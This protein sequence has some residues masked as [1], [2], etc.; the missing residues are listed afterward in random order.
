MKRFWIFI[1]LAILTATQCSHPYEEGMLGSFPYIEMTSPSSASFKANA[2]NSESMK[3]TILLNT[4]M[5]VTAKVEYNGN[6]TGWIS[7]VTSSDEGAAVKLTYTVSANTKRSAR[8]AVINILA[9]N[10]QTG[11]SV[12]VSQ[13]AYQMTGSPVIYEGDLILNSQEDIDNCIYT[14]VTGN[15]IISGDDISDLSALEHIDSVGGS[16]IIS[17]CSSL[18]DLGPL[19]DLDIDELSLTGTWAEDILTSYTGSFPRLTIDSC[20]DAPL[21]LSVLKRFTGL[22]DIV[23]ISSDIDNILAISEM[24]WLD[25]LTLSDGVT[26]VYQVEINYLTTIAPDIDVTVNNLYD[27]NVRLSL[28]MTACE[29]YSASF[30]ADLSLDGSPKE[31]GYILSQDGTFNFNTKVV[32]ETYTGSNTSLEFK[33]SALDSGQ[34]YTIWLYVISAFGDTF[35][36]APMDFTTAHVNFYTYT[37]NPLYPSWNGSS[38]TPAYNSFEAFMITDIEDGTLKALLFEEA[39]DGSLKATVPEGIIP[40]YMMAHGGGR[41]AGTEIGIGS[42][43]IALQSI[44]ADGIKDDIVFAATYNTFQSDMTESPEF[45]RPL[46]QINVNIDFSGSIGDLSDIATIGVNLDNFYKSWMLVSGRSQTY[47]NNTAYSFTAS[48][49]GNSELVNIVSGRYVM[50]HVADAARSAAV[51][52]TFDS[53]ETVSSNIVLS[54]SIEANNIYDITLNVKINRFDGT[55]TVDEVEIVDGGIIEF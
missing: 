39:A 25:S 44:D 43:I 13:E 51:T 27:D 21:N 8:K 28:Q 54:E 6:S 53:G 38:E 33:A 15:L 4:N 34:D 3:G 17:G 23:I 45:I 30:I 12:T 10:V 20:M 46:A 1:T 2:G 32:I 40:I 49:D 22:K 31:V 11:F 16:L 9:D 36:S 55:F 29:E 41:G 50:P 48:V 37:V 18:T 35:L 5:T 14:G 7:N 26:G 24:T 47:A 19:N 42:D 52:I